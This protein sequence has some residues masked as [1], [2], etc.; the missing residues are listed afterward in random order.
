MRKLGVIVRLQ[1]QLDSIK[2]GKKPSERYTPEPNL[3]AV[4]AL[5]LNSDGV[6]GVAED[7]SML[8]DVHNRT[9]PHSKFRGDNGVSI[10]FTGHYDAIRDRF[11]DHMTDGIAGESMLVQCTNMIPLEAIER[12][13]V[14][15]GDGREIT[16]GP[17]EVAHPCAPFSKFCLQFPEDARPDR[18]I[19]ETLQF[20]ENGMRGFVAVYPDDA[21]PVEIRLGDVVYVA[22]S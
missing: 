14:V 9:H 15:V 18:R 17:W 19:T 7:G 3:T 16:I 1:V 2:T 4:P 13:I 11:G 10:L 12:G 21:D 5:R 20:L 6:Y 8:P 22:D